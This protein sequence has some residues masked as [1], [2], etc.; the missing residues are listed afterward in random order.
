M[1][2]II[3]IDG[4]SGSG[5]GTVSR[6][7]A[8]KLGYHLL[9]SGAIYRIAALAALRNGVA[10]DD[11]ETLAEQSQRL[12][13]LFHVDGDSTKVLLDRCDVSVDIRLEE[14][15]IAASKIAALPLLREALLTRQR[16]FAIAPGLIADGRDMGTVVFPDAACKFYLT[17]SVEE[18]ARRRVRQLQSLG[19]GKIDEQKILNDIRTRDERDRNRATAPLKPADDAIVI[20]SSDLSIG[21][22]V[23]RL[24]KTVENVLG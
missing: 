21:E 10:L 6:L 7:L 22:V 3:T 19:Q 18:R 9:D 1:T 20:D 12:D 4:P 16:D 8:E 24:S 11:E 17:A 2:T 5:K 13:I 15:G 23:L 14:T